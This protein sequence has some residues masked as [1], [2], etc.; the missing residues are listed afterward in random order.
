MHR[1]PE[2]VGGVAGY[3]EFLKIINDANNPEHES[4]LEWAEKDTGGRK[5]SPDYFYIKEIN[6]AMAKIK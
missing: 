3:G 1:P 6:R 4:Y 5:F 2:D